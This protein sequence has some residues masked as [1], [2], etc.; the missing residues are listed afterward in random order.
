MVALG[1]LSE[2]LLVEAEQG[3]A[4]ILE[5]LRHLAAD[6][7]VRRETDLVLAVRFEL[8]RGH[9]ELD[10]HTGRRRFQRS[11]EDGFC[12]RQARVQE[13]LCSGDR[14]SLRRTGVD[15]QAHQLELVFAER[16]HGVR[17]RRPGDLDAGGQLARIGLRGQLEPQEAAILVAR[18]DAV[19][20]AFRRRDLEQVLVGHARQEIEAAGRLVAAVAGRVGALV[21]FENDFLDSLEGAAERG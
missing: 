6:V 3:A 4:R 1:I 17:H 18:L 10:A 21:V 16:P 12:R 11:D 13:R 19:E 20:G 15:P 9:F 2:I 8:P 7:I 5:R 14:A